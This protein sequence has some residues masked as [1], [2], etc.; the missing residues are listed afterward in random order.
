L[1]NCTLITCSYNTPDITLTML[2]NFIYMNGNGPHNLILME[3]STNE[4]TVKRLD[5][6]KIPYIR[7][8][9]GTHAESINTALQLCNTKYALLVDTDIIFNHPINSTFFDNLNKNNATIVG[10]ATSNR[11]G[12]KLK[13]RI[14]PW[15]CFINVED[16]KKYNIKFYDKNDER[17]INTQSQ[18]FYNN[19]P[20]NYNKNNNIEM[21]DVGATFFEDIKNAG[22]NAFSLPDLD[23]SY[24]HYEGMSWYHNVG[25][26]KHTLKSI[27]RLN[28]Y[29]KEILKY[30][31]IKLTNKFIFN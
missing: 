9:G 29:K 20:I 6:H 18:G 25:D 2:K 14:D 16:V 24:K 31:R 12:Y 17:I 10:I 3:N 4:D 30:K 1:N 21:Y 7:N 19:V 11:A 28:A 13:T 5:I 15:F 23:K 8:K 27:D 22:L 26:D